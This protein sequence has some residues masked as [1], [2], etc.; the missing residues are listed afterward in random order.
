[1]Q[2]LG[3][4]LLVLLGIAA[5]VLYTTTFIVRETTQAIVL[6]FGA[7]VGEPKTEAGLYFKLPYQTVTYF[8]KRVLNLDPRPESFLLI[9]QRPLVVDYFLR[10]RITQHTMVIVHP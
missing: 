4:A 8:D 2:R 6:E 9:D 10:Y 7:E 3:V 5:A 1:M